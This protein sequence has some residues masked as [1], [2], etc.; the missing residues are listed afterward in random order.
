[1]KWHSLQAKKNFTTILSQRWFSIAVIEIAREIESWSGDLA[2]S[3]R[4]FLGKRDERTAEKDCKQALH[5]ETQSFP[6]SP[7]ND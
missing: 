6:F 4:R 2:C 5:F 1:M 7:R 3:I